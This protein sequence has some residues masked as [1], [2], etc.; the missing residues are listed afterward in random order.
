MS[1]AFSWG[2]SMKVV[3]ERVVYCVDADKQN[4]GFFVR[5]T[6]Y[7]DDG[8][9]EYVPRWLPD[10]QVS[11]YVTREKY[12]THQQKKEYEEMS[13]LKEIKATPVTMARAIGR[14]LG[15]NQDLHRL[16][17]SPYVYGLS[18]HPTA[19]IKYRYAKKYQDAVT[20]VKR[21]AAFDIETSMK[22]ES[23]IIAG[24]T[25]KDK[26]VVAVRRDFMSHLAV[27]DRDMTELVENALDAQL[28]EVL[29]RRNVD[30]EVVWCD[31]PAQLVIECVERLHKW[32]P[33]FVSVWNINFDLPRC[34][35]ALEAENY[36][37]TDIFCDPCVPH[38]FRHCEYVAGD[39]SKVKAGEEKS[40]HVADI[41]NYLDCPSGFMW[42]DSM[43]I[44][45]QLRLAEGMLPSYSLEYVLT[46]ELGHG[47]LKCN[48][49]GKGGPW[50]TEMQRNYPAEYVAYNLYDC[51]GL[52]ELDEKT[53]DLSVSL[54]IFCGFLPVEEFHRSSKRSESKYYFHALSKG[55][56]MGVPSYNTGIPADKRLPNRS[57][58]IA[59]LRSD[60]IRLKGIQVFDDLETPTSRVYMHSSDFDV[61][62][63]YPNIQT[64]LNISRTTMRLETLSLGDTDYHERRYY[65][66]ALLGG[67]VNAH[68]V[69]RR[70]FAMPSHEKM[71][72]EFMSQSENE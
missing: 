9:V 41:W 61:T 33:D 36:R 48:V 71:L 69:S 56:V 26:A 3:A 22:D 55:C 25:F 34:I 2:N 23:I 65:G 38:E 24:A 32:M 35:A 8:R 1:I 44:Y 12:R 70:L 20:K 59:I 46:R 72:D 39:K 29:K 47:K 10:I 4:D 50:H 11:M 27:T 16:A 53:L 67:D 63:T 13:K 52:E 40:L 37:L 19:I 49:P 6:R 31:T 51:I 28:G 43:Y 14:A 60:M 15:R 21:I 18:M 62:G 5:E 68:Q 42:I 54:P 17:A 66:S 58:W 30:V 45:R 57:D 7:H 64:Q